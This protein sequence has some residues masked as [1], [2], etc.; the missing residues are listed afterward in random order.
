MNTFLLACM[1]LLYAE[2]IVLFFLSY[3]SKNLDSRDQ[4]EERTA[5]QLWTQSESTGSGSGCFGSG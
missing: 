4:E 5:L 1:H 2:L 3:P